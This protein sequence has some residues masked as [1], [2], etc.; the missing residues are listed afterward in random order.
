MRIN[1][2]AMDKVRDIKPFVPLI[3]DNGI[4]LRHEPELERRL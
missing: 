1:R 4:P 2:N 3:G